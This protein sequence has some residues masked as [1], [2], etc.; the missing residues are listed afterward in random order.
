MK[1]VKT[2]AMRICRHLPVLA[3]I[4]ICAL[5]AAST[6]AGQSE[7]ETKRAESC[8][9]VDLA[10]V[11][12]SDMEKIVRSVG[13][14]EAA[15]SVVVYPEIGGVIESVNFEEGEPVEKGKL[16][17]A[18]DSDKIRAR[19]RAQKAALE[20]ARAN[21]E[22]A[23]LVYQRRQRLYEKDLGTEEAR[24]QARTTYQ[25]LSAQVKR[26]KAEIENINETLKDT[27]IRAPFDGIMDEQLVDAGQLVNTET[28]LSSI[29]ETDRLKI[30][31]TVPERYM[32]MVEKGQEIRVTTPAYPEKTFSGNVYFISPQISKTTRSLLVKARLDNPEGVLRPGGFVSVELIVDILENVPVIPEEALVPT[33]S[34][35]MVFTVKNSH[36]KQQNVEIGLRRPGTVEIKKG[37]E[38]GETIV[39]AGHISLYQGARVC[40]E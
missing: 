21:L 12:N 32:G 24:D 22:N 2:H 33:R 13:N 34:G 27:R 15:Q 14:V 5:A 40:P 9:P 7:D 23:R 20:E 28:A 17:F 29:V 16:I 4:L 6:A 36:A 8:V 30:A 38:Q 39:R 31:F 37:L 10:T 19:L 1:A 26:I 25:A 35:Y 11:E 18:I 3:A